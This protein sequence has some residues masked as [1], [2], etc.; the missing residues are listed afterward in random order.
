MIQ[1]GYRLSWRAGLFHWIKKAG[2]RPIG[3]CEALRRIIG[4]A[5]MDIFKIDALKAAGGVQLCAGHE[6]SAVAAMRAMRTT[7]EE[8]AT[9]A[10]LFVDAENAFNNLNRKVALLNIRFVCPSISPILINC[11]R[12]STSLFVGRSVISSQEGTTQGDPLAMAMFAMASIP[13][14]QRIACERNV[15]TWC[16]DDAASGGILRSIRQWW[17]NLS[18]HGPKYGY[19]ANV[20]KTFLL[21]KNEKF[22]EAKEIFAGT[23]IR[24]TIEG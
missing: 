1:Q 12:E 20:A 21:V 13:F 23:G 14:A 18:V 4:N 10:I 6:S 3:I 5:V 24:I 11:Y 15:Q 2:V 16:A 19:F 8:A 17:D 9:D 22:S 7:F